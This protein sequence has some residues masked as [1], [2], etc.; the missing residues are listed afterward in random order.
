[1]KT[2]RTF[3]AMLSFITLGLLV[4]SVA[5]QNSDGYAESFESYAIGTSITNVAGWSAAEATSMIVSTNYFADYDG[6]DFPINYNHNTST[7]VLKVENG[8]SNTVAAGANSQTNWVDVVIKPVLSDSA[9][10]LPP[11]GSV[12]AVYFNSDSNL[13]VG[14]SASVWDGTLSWLPIPDVSVSPDKWTRLT[15]AANMRD[16][17]DEHEAVR[18]F[19]V[20]VNGNIVTN[21]AA[22]TEP[23][24]NS[25]LGG[26]WFAGGALLASRNEPITN[27][28]VNGTGYIDDLVLTNSLTL[29]AVTTWTITASAGENGSITPSGSV[30]VTDGHSQV[31]T[32]TPNSGYLVDD[33]VVV[34]NGA[35]NSLGS[36]TDYTFTNVIADGSITASF[37]AEPPPTWTI[38]ASAGENGSIDPAG[39]VEVTNGN[40]QAFTITPDS[41]YL[42]DDVVVVENG[43]TNSLGSVTDY[44][45]TNVIADGSITASFVAEPPP[46]WTITASAG[47]NGSIDPAGIVEVTNGNSQAFTITPVSGYLV[48]D[49]VV[50]ENGATNSLGSVTG[51]TF[52]NVI[53]DGSITASFVDTTANGTPIAYYDQFGLTPAGEGVGTWEELDALDSDGDGVP[54]W[55]EFVAGTDPTS[56]TSV[57]RILGATVTGGNV[58]L[59]W[60]GGTNGPIAPYI[61]E[62]ATSLVGTTIGWMNVTNRNRAE[63]VNSVTNIPAQGMMFFR[64]L[65][66]P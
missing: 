60:Y 35:T 3:S 4:G 5:A 10:A 13:V 49:V 29:T 33:V 43:A 8:V 62:G 34:E 36:V 2:T 40:S 9:P 20:Y 59:D 42:V 14:H 51:Y 30:E 56:I 24:A 54:N 64:V 61:V 16:G 66:T 55:Q 57:F 1:M 48:D 50:V 44:T 41:G 17:N 18:Y 11:V 53:A 65:A 22:Y 27:V 6:G 58:Q 25:A 31:F 47:E 63:G 38:T 19:K 52:T 45:F 28:I 23:S 21:G 15:I 46:T 7:K 12:A 26:S 32:I 39:S 37:V